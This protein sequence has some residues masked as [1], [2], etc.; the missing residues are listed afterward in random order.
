[1]NNFI[2]GTVALIPYNLIR[3][4]FV[5]V[6]VSFIPIVIFQ[7]LIHDLKLVNDTIHSFLE[8]GPLFDFL[9]GLTALSIVVASINYLY[10]GKT[11]SFLRSI[12]NEVGTGLIC[13]L[14]LA[15]GPFILQPIID[16]NKVNVDLILSIW[17]YGI[18][19]YI[20]CAVMSSYNQH[21]ETY[22]YKRNYPNNLI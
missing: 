12:F 16:F 13:S 20:F 17:S 18:G 4:F 7:F 21:L 9:L 2:R 14:R 11:I 22:F 19:F 5:I 10:R 1:M 6:L 8:H 3:E 15:T